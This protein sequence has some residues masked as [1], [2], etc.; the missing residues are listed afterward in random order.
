[1]EAL[2]I[3]ENR[4]FLEEALSVLGRYA[5]VP[6]AIHLL[7]QYRA[8]VAA[9]DRFH[10]TYVDIDEEEIFEPAGVKSILQTPSEDHHGWVHLRRRPANVPTPAPVVEAPVERPRAVPGMAWNKVV[11]LSPSIPSTPVVAPKESNAPSE[12]HPEDGEP[13]D[14]LELDDTDVLVSIDD[15]F[16]NETHNNDLLLDVLDA[17]RDIAVRYQCCEGVHSTSFVN[18]LSELVGA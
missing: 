3:N 1:M 8:P 7:F 15:T 14:E 17:V 12:T 4:G 6:R 9:L 10:E 11:A 5:N 13:E 2:W 18:A 16:E